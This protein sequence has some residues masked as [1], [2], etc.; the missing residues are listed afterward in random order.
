MEFIAAVNRG[1]YRP[2]GREINQWRLQPEPKPLRKGKLLEPEIPREAD[3][4]V[5]KRK[6]DATGISALVDSLL[7]SQQVADASSRQYANSIARELA[8]LNRR[9]FSGLFNTGQFAG[10]GL[11]DEWEYETIPGKPGKPA[12]YA[13]D[14]PRRSSSR[15]FDGWDGSIAMADIDTAS[16][17]SVMPCSQ[18]RSWRSRSSKT[19]PSLCLRLRIRTWATARF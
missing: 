12:V 19:R 3:R 4:R 16:L 5:R 8:G 14:K 15:T 1:G 11:F 10:L 7:K 9:D 6:R 17:C 13:P 18:P 2:T